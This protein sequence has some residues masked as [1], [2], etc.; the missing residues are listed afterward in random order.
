MIA[1]VRFKHV[2]PDSSPIKQVK[3]LCDDVINDAISPGS[4]MR[5]DHICTPIREHCI[6][7]SFVEEEEAF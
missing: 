4:T 2:G 3:M 6:K 1:A 5:E 7:V